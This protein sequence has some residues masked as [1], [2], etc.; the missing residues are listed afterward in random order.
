LRP[1]CYVTENTGVR[2]FITRVPSLNPFGDGGIILLSIE[3]HRVIGI[4][5]WSTRQ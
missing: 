3:S 1:H 4:S 5:H 2:N